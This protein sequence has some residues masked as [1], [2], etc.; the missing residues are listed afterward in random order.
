[1]NITRVV[2]HHLNSKAAQSVD[3]SGR[4]PQVNERGIIVAVHDGD[5]IPDSMKMVDWSSSKPRGGSPI[6][7]DG[8]TGFEAVME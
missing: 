5:C 3:W 1:M 6:E 4:W 2:G 8:N 7:V